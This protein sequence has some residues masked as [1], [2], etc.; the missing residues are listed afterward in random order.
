[1]ATGCLVIGIG[2]ATKEMQQF[3]KC[4]KEYVAEGVF[5][6]ATDTYDVE[7]RVVKLAPLHDVSQQQLNDV[8]QKYK[9]EG[10]QIPPMY[11]ALRIDGIRLYEYA[12]NGMP[13]PDGRKVEARPIV[14]N[15]VELLDFESPP[16][17]SE[18]QLD[19]A[20]KEFRGPTF[21]VR[22]DS[23]GG[24]YVRSFIH[25]VGE[26]V[27]SAAFMTS[28]CRTRQG[29]F[30]L[31]DA[32]GLDDVSAEKVVEAIEKCSKLLGAHSKADLKGD[33]AADLQ[34]E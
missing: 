22:I 11:S 23:G 9:G 13:L 16:E 15:D 10:T 26:D 17:N 2:T 21:K 5:G 6:A 34:T 25:D 33:L 31:K 12:R 19:S 18:T 28:L 24:F 14:V 20:A 30:T 3:L 7:G 8:V 32:I 29:N 27:N 1:M 4:T